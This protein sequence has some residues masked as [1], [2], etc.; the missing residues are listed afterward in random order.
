MIKTNNKKI[1]IVVSSL[2]G[3]GA[4]RSSAL[5]SEILY[6]LG[7]NIYIIS[8]LDNIEFSFK[9]K[10][11]NLGE[12][13][14]KDDSVIG[15]LK[16]LKVFKDFIKEHSFDYVIDSRPRIVFFKEF[17]ISKFI[18]TPKKTM[19]FVRSYKVDSYINSNRILGKLLYANANK[20]IAVSNAISKKVTDKYGLKN[21]SC[22]YNPVEIKQDDS[23]SEISE[24]YILFFGRLND[25]VK[26]ISLLL[27][28]Y[29]KSKLPI[30]NIGLKILGDGKDLEKLKE[31]VKVLK[32]SSNIQFLPHNP[33]PS[34]IIQSALFTVLTSRYEGFPR[35]I[36]ES[37][38]FGTPVVSVDCQSGPNEIIINEF[39]GLLVEN[40][41]PEVLAMAMNRLYE[42]KDLYLHCK[43]NTKTSVEQLSKSA[44]GLQWKAILK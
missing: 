38:A 9:G 25:E 35:V 31:L 32:L 5:L 17:I 21:V 30:Q 1:C 15:R 2:G 39:N 33:N 27:E 11:L 13:K 29:S 19:Y 3:G 18:Y 14:A 41:N 34:T 20:I 40:H 4:E 36:T 37:L 28:A 23:E 16:R 7:H 26:N 8:V 22:I 43:S 12:L 6:D 24:P 44:I 42:D 10:L